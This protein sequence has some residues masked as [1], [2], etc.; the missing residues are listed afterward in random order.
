MFLRLS[1]LLILGVV[2]GLLVRVMCEMLLLH[3]IPYALKLFL[4]GRSLTSAIF[5]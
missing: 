4:V 5:T 1:V 3:E 2:L